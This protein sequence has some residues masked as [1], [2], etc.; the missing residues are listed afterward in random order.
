MAELPTLFRF[1]SMSRLCLVFFSIFLFACGG[2]AD[3][4]KVVQGKARLIYVPQNGPEAALEWIAYEDDLIAP[5]KSEAESTGTDGADRGPADYQELSKLLEEKASE[6]L[7]FPEKHG[8]ELSV[9]E[10]RREPSKDKDH[11]GFQIHVE[12]FTFCKTLPESVTLGYSN[13]FPRVRTAQLYWTHSGK[14]DLTEIDKEGPVEL[15]K[16]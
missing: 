13:F 3:P 7:Q 9:E 5:E 15:K 2:D 1:S 16:P 4:E 14:K 6:M 8:C 12:Y 11:P 10:I